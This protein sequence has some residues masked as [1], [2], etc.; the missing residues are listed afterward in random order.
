MDTLLQDLRHGLRGLWRDR[1]FTLVAVLTLAL[2]IGANA[3]IYSFL[4]ALVLR[5]LDLPEV[6]RL[7]HLYEQSKDD[8]RFSLSAPNFQDVRARVPQLEHVAAYARRE[9]NLTG[10]GEPETLTN[11]RVSPSFF[12]ALGVQ[13]ALGRTLLADEDEPGKQYVTVLSHGL[14]QRRF[15]ADP[16]VVGRTVTLDG[17]PYT[18][19]GVLPSNFAFLKPAQLYTPLVFAPQETSQRRSHF[20]GVL[21]RLKAGATEAQAASALR[22]VLD[23]QHPEDQTHL[24]NLTPLIEAS[25]PTLRRMMWVLMA[26]V[27]LVLLAA[28]ANVAGMLLARAARREREMAIRAAL[29]ASRLRMVRLLLTESLLL[30]LL[31]GGFGLLIALWGVDLMRAGMPADRAQALLGWDKAGLNARMLLFTLGTVSLATVVVGLMPALRASRTDP[32]ATLRVEGRGAAGSV[33]RHR[34]RQ[35][36]VGAQMAFALMLTVG[37]CL[38]ARSF[39]TLSGPHPG[40]ERAGVLT[41]RVVADKSNFP[42]QADAARFFSTMEERLR[43]L[44]GVTDA[45]AVSNIPM[46]PSITMLVLDVEGQPTPPPGQEVLANSL[47]VTPDYFRTLRIPLRE[48]EGFSGREQVDGLQVAIISAALARRAFG[49]EPAVGKRIG[50]KPPQGETKDWFTVVGVVGDVQQQPPTEPFT[51]AESLYLPLPQDVPRSMTFTVRTTGEPLALVASVR[52]ELAALDSDVPL[53]SVRTLEDVVDA[54]FTNSRYAMVLMLVFAAVALVLSAVGLYGV[55]AYGVSQRAREIGIRMALGARGADVTRLIVGQALWPTGVGLGVGLVGAY[56]VAGAMADILFGV[57]PRDPLAFGSMAVLLLGVAAL[58]VLG[59][60][61][62]AV[63]VDPA[64]SF[65]SE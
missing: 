24:L 32:G 11:L 64:V 46:G 15:G 51:R 40:F 12:T 54:A 6:E 47:V 48:G 55:M 43:A 36:L 60:V 28:C 56:A 37:A 3:S 30:A 25:N 59:P 2:G 18:V 29:G 26:A 31:G 21:G 5:P 62:T 49:S 9:S 58:A 33:E 27:V 44:P 50:F 38:T 35:A 8:P 34:L 16:S 39:A 22:A 61:R 53:T 42:N 63:R 13:A 1:T 14:W 20:L 41:F 7:V 45:A 19:V 23:G 17:Q 65:R 4:D 52:R 57:N 10:S